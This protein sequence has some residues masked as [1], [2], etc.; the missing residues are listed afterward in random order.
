M[1]NPTV[2]AAVMLFKLWVFPL[3]IFA[4]PVALFVKIWITEQRPLPLISLLVLIT[5]GCWFVTFNYL[6]AFTLATV[7]HGVQYLAI[8]LIF[9]VR[10]QK[11][12][13]GNQH[14][15]F[16]HV[17][18]FY[19]WSLALGYGLFHCLPWAYRLVGFGVVESM[20]LVAA[21]INIHHF[22]VDAYIWKLGKQDSNRKIVDSAQ[23]P[24]LV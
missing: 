8:V 17:A 2:H 18:W 1:T 16:V 9:H 24:A 19:G 22:I 13:P 23:A 3:L 4:L 14:G 15:T 5:N 12:R 10:D 11:Q 20:L 7:F 6:Q 21:A